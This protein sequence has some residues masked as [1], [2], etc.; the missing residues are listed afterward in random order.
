MRA[1]TP[2]PAAPVTA[3]DAEAAYQLVLDHAGAI[4][5]NRDPVDARIV[6]EVRDGTA[7]YGGTYGA[8]LGI[9]DS[10]ATVGGWPEMH[11]AP[12]PADTDHDGMPDDWERRFGFEPGDPSDGPQD[13]DSDGYTNLEE[14]L[15]GT[16]PA[17]FVD[18]RVRR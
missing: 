2:F 8:G 1:S 13:K 18:Y 7:T 3:Q 16:G 12:A 15:N 6:G 17:E 14:Y 5:P 4:L 10:P 11:S 9:I